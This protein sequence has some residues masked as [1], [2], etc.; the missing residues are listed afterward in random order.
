M[1]GF[2]K[3]CIVHTSN[4]STTVWHDN[5]MVV[6]FY[7]LPRNRLDEVVVILIYGSP[8]FVLYLVVIYTRFASSLWI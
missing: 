7:G 1:T 3:M 2:V 6:K 8:V 4:F 5:F